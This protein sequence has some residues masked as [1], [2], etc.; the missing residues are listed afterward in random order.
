MAA[1]RGQRF[2]EK[3]QS[4]GLSGIQQQVYRKVTKKGFD[5]NL[6][7]A[8]ETGLG[9]STL[10]ETL[11]MQANEQNR[12]YLPA[13]HR[14]ERTVEVSPRTKVITDNGL[15]L[16]LT[17][18]DTPGFSDAVNNNECWAP[19]VSFIHQKFEQYLQDETKL[20]RKTI[21]D[22]RV[23]C[24]LYFINPSNR[25]LRLLDIETL[26]ALHQKVNVIPVIAKAD[27]LS[28]LEL[29][30]LKQQIKDD[31]CAHD[32]KIFTPAVDEE[33]DQSVAFTYLLLDALPFALVGST[34][35]F[36]SGGR[37]IRGRQYPWGIVEVDNA[38]HCDY[39]LLKD[40]LV[41]THLQDLKDVTNEV[42]Y[43]NFRKDA[44][45]SGRVALTQSYLADQTMTQEQDKLAMSETELLK[46]HEQMRRELEE[47]EK[48]LEMK[49]RMFEEDRRRFDEEQKRF[50]KLSG[51]SF[52]GDTW[53]LAKYVSVC[54][55]VVVV[56]VV[57]GLTT[58]FSIQGGGDGKAMMEQWSPDDIR[59][60]LLHTH[61]R[62][63]IEWLKGYS[64]AERKKFWVE[65]LLEVPEEASFVITVAKRVQKI[66]STLLG[67]D[68]FPMGNSSDNAN[69][70]MDKE[71]Y[72]EE[73]I[74]PFT[75]AAKHI[76]DMN[77]LR[78]LQN[79]WN[80][81]RNTLLKKPQR[82][83]V[84]ISTTVPGCK[85]LQH[86]C[87]HDV[88]CVV[89][90]PSDQE[91]ELLNRMVTAC[92]SFSIICG[93]LVCTGRPGE[94]D[95]SKSIPTSSD[96]LKESAV[97]R[98][99][100]LRI[101]LLLRQPNDRIFPSQA[102][103]QQEKTRSSSASLPPFYIFSPLLTESVDGISLIKQLRRFTQLDVQHV[104][105]ITTCFEGDLFPPK[106]FLS[107]TVPTTANN[108]SLE[109]VEP[110]ISDIFFEPA[111]L[112]AWKSA[113]VMLGELSHGCSEVFRAIKHSGLSMMA[114]RQL[115]ACIT[116]DAGWSTAKEITACVGELR[117]WLC[118]QWPVIQEQVSSPYIY[119][120][121]D[122]HLRTGV[123]PEFPDQTPMAYRHRIS[124]ILT[125]LGEWL[126]ER[127]TA[128]NKLH[129]AN[130]TRNE[131][132]AAVRIQE[133][134][135]LQQY[136]RN[137]YELHDYIYL[138]TN[139]LDQADSPQ[140]SIGKERGSHDSDS[141]QQGWTSSDTDENEETRQEKSNNRLK[142]KT[143]NQSL[144]QIEHKMYS[145]I[146]C[147]LEQLERDRL[148]SIQED[149]RKAASHPSVCKSHVTHG[150]VLSKSSIPENGNAG[151]QS[152]LEQVNDDRSD[153]HADNHLSIRPPLP[154]EHTLRFMK[155]W[156]SSE[157]RFLRVIDAVEQFDGIYLFGGRLSFVSQQSERLKSYSDENIKS[158]MW[159]TSASMMKSRFENKDYDSCTAQHQELSEEGLE[160]I[161]GPQREAQESAKAFG[162]VVCRSLAFFTDIFP[163]LDA[164]Q[165]HHIEADEA[166]NH[167]QSCQP[168]LLNICRSAAEFA[169]TVDVMTA[170]LHLADA[171]WNDVT[172]N[173]MQLS[174]VW[175]QLLLERPVYQPSFVEMRHL[176][177]ARLKHVQ[178]CLSR[179]CHR[180]SVLENGI[181]S[182][183]KSMNRDPNS[184]GIL[185][186]C[187]ELML[188]VIQLF[189]STVG[190][191]ARHRKAASR[192]LAI[193]L[194]VGS[195]HRSKASTKAKSAD[196]I[197][198]QFG[199]Q[200]MWS[201]T[202]P[203][204]DLPL[205]TSTTGSLDALL[206]TTQ[207]Q[208][209]EGTLFV[210]CVDII[211]DN[212]AHDMRRGIQQC[213]HLI[214]VSIDIDV[215]DGQRQSP[216]SSRDHTGSDN[217]NQ[218]NLSKIIPSHGQNVSSNS[219]GYDLPDVVITPQIPLLFGSS[220]VH[221]AEFDEAVR[222]R[223]QLLYDAYVSDTSVHFI[224]IREHTKTGDGVVL[225]STSALQVQQLLF[226][227]DQRHASF[228]SAT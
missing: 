45:S 116:Y 124:N 88:V 63:T 79:H 182:V 47:Q 171:T 193:Q 195:Q 165:L 140:D 34:E 83:L 224:R 14:I 11:F 169:R 49:R 219:S 10:M 139:A 209:G 115:A 57:L 24:L 130:Q 106:T 94:I 199:G 149:L 51:S 128:Y 77:S 59:E 30:E 211:C 89:F 150:P 119:P 125:C 36:Q 198:S 28:K 31:I 42:L 204:F 17:I 186:H 225:A 87:R 23:H 143:D 180:I 157:E 39:N 158:D 185:F 98:E 226:A 178:L 100:W 194:R 64:I 213:K 136:L 35:T 188:E 132:V 112:F 162:S 86:A 159:N 137:L 177:V 105:E 5:F 163:V 141:D 46:R 138:S 43:E 216:F 66:H 203:K 228:S 148:Q 131:E 187:S 192:T 26:K 52:T 221:Q 212:A 183:M 32:I 7:V 146:N 133:L 174:T 99:L 54:S 15:Q 72:Q 129:I 142:K 91:E 107:E 4:V 67:T 147:K 80:A 108:S 85:M 75:T 170:N 55:T 76:N 120:E 78:S 144:E 156:I 65:V 109:D 96:T 12:K 168:H 207:R 62:T 104:D 122:N 200:L 114:D 70:N 20:D 44:L 220:I 117:H 173:N 160:R 189:R 16:K 27:T 113:A 68:E 191:V 95:I 172:L 2:E 175:S 206:Y 155:R 90:D 19:L 166:L 33:D 1:R 92:T 197:S 167:I 93:A 134:E 121:L 135:D 190:N 118:T 164:A 103:I 21:S 201:Y 9:K 208:V 154:S 102:Q 82:K 22:E 40:M 97:V 145:S 181:F 69:E 38:D 37:M 58:G 8:G 60:D 6:M 152:V 205:D 50:K 217:A 127:A 13:S 179:L 81:K 126:I 3:R 61:A 161:F 218:F 210:W 227:L 48:L 151:R 74:K 101:A 71:L 123:L 111:S 56:K 41:R 18:I 25:G 223:N 84:I 73:M 202:H 215:L 214:L 110:T 176:L 53:M 196:F 29:K 222:L 153:S 184:Q